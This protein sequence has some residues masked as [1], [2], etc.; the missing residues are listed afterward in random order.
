MKTR[1]VIRSALL[2]LICLPQNVMAQDK[3]YHFYY[4][5]RGKVVRTGVKFTLNEMAILFKNAKALP[6]RPDYG[7]FVFVDSK[8]WEENTPANASWE[9]T[10]TMAKRCREESACGGQ[11]SSGRQV[12]TVAGPATAGGSS[13]AATCEQQY[14]VS[15]SRCGA[16]GVLQTQ[17]MSGTAK[18]I[19]SF[20]GVDPAAAAG[21]VL[22]QPPAS[23]AAL[24]WRESTSQKLSK[25]CRAS[26]GN[27]RDIL[28]WDGT[29]NIR[30]VDERVS[31]CP[32]QALA[33]SKGAITLAHTTRK[34]TWSNPPHP[35]DLLP[36]TRELT[37]WRGSGTA[38]SLQ[39]EPESVAGQD[40]PIKVNV[41]YTF[42]GR[43]LD[44]IDIGSRL[45]VRM[46]PALAKIAG[47][48]GHCIYEMDAVA[49]R[50][51]P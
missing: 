4:C 3:M 49:E 21:R 28:L 48:G 42:N 14:T 40:S 45:Q 9:R 38:W 8:L 44:R 35:T 2:A 50:V 20:T 1:V 12:A 34:V 15:I 41:D 10:S 47:F 18:Q 51:N 19:K 29:W 16:D 30:V 13:E 27:T 23:G 32:A 11:N 43:A 5:E 22:Y 7:R 46:T 6:P 37:A 39:Y 31:D 17:Q 24:E 25:E 26:A 33:M 36:Q